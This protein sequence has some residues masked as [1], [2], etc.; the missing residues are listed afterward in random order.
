MN[1]KYRV[2][3][4]QTASSSTG[5]ETHLQWLARGLAR[6]FSRVGRTAARWAGILG[7]AGQ[8]LG[9]NGGHISAAAVAYYSLVSFFPLVLLL[10]SVLGFV[11]PLTTLAE[12]LVTLGGDLLPGMSD[13]FRESIRQ[14][15]QS[16]GT[17]GLTALVTLYWSASGMFA[18]LAR[19][20]DLVYDTP[21]NLDPAL[22]FAGPVKMPPL[23][24]V[25]RR[26]R[27]MGVVAGVGVL[28]FLSVLA[29]TYLRLAERAAAAPRLGPF[30]PNTALALLRALPILVT[31]G[32]F[33]AIYAAVPRRAPPWRSLLP[34]TV[35]AT[36]LFEL[37][38]ST[39]AWYATRLRANSWIYGSL[40]TTIV[41]L[42]WL[43]IIAVVVIYGAEVGAVSGADP[44]AR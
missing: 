39:F 32:V 27:A 1:L 35:T 21:V 12:K 7:R 40:T 44:E 3:P 41:L 31:A 22:A 29:T 38:K 19:T 36:V 11:F 26:L 23:A 17:L 4:H 24:G 9:Y 43:Y 2:S 34:A 20:L 42:V 18:T 33:L 14:V 30:G 15:V 8:R 13:F 37:A 16:R 5:H 10:L 6:G 28:L 25:V